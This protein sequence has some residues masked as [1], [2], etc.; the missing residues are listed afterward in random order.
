MSDIKI[1]EQ[2][3]D[4]HIEVQKASNDR[5][6]T[7]L[8]KIGESLV[9]LV[10]FQARAEERHHNTTKTMEKLQARVDK[11]WDMVHRNSLVVNGVVAV[12][13]AVAIW[14]VRGWLG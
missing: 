4:S 9:A 14:L 3:I 6:E 1:L 5:V 10:G 2:K 7:T 11:L 8:E 13:T 12:V